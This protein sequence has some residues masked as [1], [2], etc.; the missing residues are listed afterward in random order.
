MCPTD[1][2][3]LNCTPSTQGFKHLYSQEFDYL[4]QQAVEPTPRCQCERLR[5]TVS[6]G[7]QGSSKHTGLQIHT[8]MHPNLSIDVCLDLAVVYPTL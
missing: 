7:I 2:F 6:K 5:N 4:S 8:L 1:A 3:L